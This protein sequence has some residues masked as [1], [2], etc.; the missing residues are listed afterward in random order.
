MPAPIFI[1]LGQQIG[2]GLKKGAS[3]WKAGVQAGKV[4]AGNE[5]A[6]NATTITSAGSTTLTPTGGNKNNMM[7]IIAGLVVAVLVFVGF[8][9]K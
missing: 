2:K 6:G 7:L 9:K 4:G 3:I 1:A 8:K 5:L